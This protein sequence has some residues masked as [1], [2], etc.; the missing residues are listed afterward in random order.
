VAA[1]ARR[2][3]SISLMLRT[4]ARLL[5]RPVQPN[6]DR[7]LSKSRNRM[8]ALGTG[9]VADAQVTSKRNKPQGRPFQ[10][11]FPAGRGRPPA[12]VRGSQSAKRGTL[13]HERTPDTPVGCRGRPGT[14][15]ALTSRTTAI[16]AGIGVRAVWPHRQAFRPLRPRG[17]QSGGEPP[18]AS[19]PLSMSRTRT[20]RGPGRRRAVRRDGPQDRF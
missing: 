12:R 3:T 4:P 19:A 7:A 14:W 1:A 20:P 10:G 9:A 11:R 2:D 6:C 5:R 18:Y 8:N 13:G 15:W 16:S 17:I